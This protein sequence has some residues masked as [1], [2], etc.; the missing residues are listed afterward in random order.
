MYSQPWSAKPRD[1][2]GRLVTVIDWVVVAVVLLMFRAMEGMEVL[3][4]VFEIVFVREFLR[5]VNSA[6]MIAMNAMR[7]AVRTRED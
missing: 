7:T 6:R 5:G 2:Q 4:K 3:A 1:A